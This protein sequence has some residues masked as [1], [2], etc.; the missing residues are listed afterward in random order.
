MRLM[1]GIQGRPSLLVTVDE[2][3]NRNYFDF[4]VINGA[5]RG[6]FK[7]GDIYVED[8]TEPTGSKVE[9]LTDNQDRLRCGQRKSD[10]DYNAVFANFDKPDL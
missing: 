2:N 9:I 10:N 4:E 3:F 7:M 5:W 6:T 1:L 8:D